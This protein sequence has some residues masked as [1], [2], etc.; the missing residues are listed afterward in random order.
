MT[1][2]SDGFEIWE[3]S[4]FFDLEKEEKKETLDMEAKE[5]FFFSF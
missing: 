1:H 3:S 5:G 4:Q 2:T